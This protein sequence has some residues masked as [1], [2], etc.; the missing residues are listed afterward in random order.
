MH[1]MDKRAITAAEIIDRLRR[2]AGQ[3]DF[4]YHTVRVWVETTEMGE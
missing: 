4:D 3:D 2:V 1:A